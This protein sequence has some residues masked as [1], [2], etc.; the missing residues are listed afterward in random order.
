MLP[1]FIE[2][3]SIKAFRIPDVRMY[4]LSPDL[5]DVRISFINSDFTKSGFYNLHRI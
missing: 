2:S 3:G 5:K 1:D 4:W